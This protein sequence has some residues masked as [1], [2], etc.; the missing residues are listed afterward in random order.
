MSKVIH[1]TPHGQLEAE[2]SKQNADRHTGLQS[3]KAIFRTIH[4]ALK[5]P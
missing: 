3:G 4:F 5:Q 1:L 2:Q